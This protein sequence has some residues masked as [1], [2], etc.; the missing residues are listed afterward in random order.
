MLD[1]NN[2]LRIRQG[3]QEG[4][5]TTCMSSSWREMMTRDLW[6]TKSQDVTFS[7]QSQGK[8]KHLQRPMTDD[9]NKLRRQCRMGLEGY[10]YTQLFSKSA[11]WKL[12]IPEE[13]IAA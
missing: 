13:H 1:T 10:T 4:I 9:A 12:P 8:L 2:H 3:D 6:F 11:A 7:L 5:R